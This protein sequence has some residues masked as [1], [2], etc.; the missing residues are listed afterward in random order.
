MLHSATLPVKIEGISELIKIAAFSQME[1]WIAAGLDDEIWFY[2]SDEYLDTKNYY[3][4]LKGL[5]FESGMK[6]SSQS[7]ARFGLERD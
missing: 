2:L 3:S 7:G 4:I 6:I 1:E 5:A